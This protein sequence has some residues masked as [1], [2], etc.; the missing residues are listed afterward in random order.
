MCKQKMLMIDD[1]GKIVPVLNNELD[2]A[3]LKALVIVVINACNDAGKNV[4]A[5]RIETL[6]GLAGLL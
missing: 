1:N 3:V 4:D 2:R 5:E 6:A